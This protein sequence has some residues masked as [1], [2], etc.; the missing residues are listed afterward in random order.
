MTSTNSQRQSEQWSILL[1]KLKEIAGHPQAT[2]NTRALAA[3]GIR[4]LERRLA[5]AGK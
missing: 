3:H 4:L 1:L 2:A 5:G